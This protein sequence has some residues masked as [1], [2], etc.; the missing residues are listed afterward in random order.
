MALKDDI[1][2]RFAQTLEALA[3]RG[4]K[5]L[6]EQGHVAT[7]KLLR[8]IEAQITSD[9]IDRLVG[10][11]Y[12]E[13]YGLIVD[14]GVPAG[15]VPF[16]PGSGAR[17]SKYI[18]ALLDWID[19]IKPG[20]VDRERRSF[21]FAIANAHKRE[22]IPTAASSRFSKDGT[23][24]NWIESSFADQEEEIEKELQLQRLISISFERSLRLAAS[25]Q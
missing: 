8:S 17:S 12:A 18:E 5:R 4:R 25:G 15:R 14:Q 3:D 21:A 19:V 1:L 2:R 22:G 24:L 10:S 13:D 20:L 9:D 16:N 7:G 6:A 11:I 23:R